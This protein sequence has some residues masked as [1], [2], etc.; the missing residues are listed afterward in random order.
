MHRTLWRMMRPWHYGRRIL[1]I[2]AYGFG[3]N[4]VKVKYGALFFSNISERLLQ[5]SLPFLL[6]PIFVDIC[7]CYPVEE[8]SSVTLETH[9][10]DDG[11][12][13]CLVSVLFSFRFRSSYSTTISL[14]CVG[15]QV[16]LQV[17]MH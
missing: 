15:K 8:V 1:H 7:N 14:S 12:L 13:S 10:E 3:G 17:H 2:E 6:S 4:I 9:S 5:L 11:V 16:L